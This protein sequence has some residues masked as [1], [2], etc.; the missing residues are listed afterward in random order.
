MTNYAITTKTDA[1]SSISPSLNVE[2]DVVNIAA[3]AADYVPELYLDLGNMQAGDTTIVTEY[4]SVDGINQ[5][6]YFQKTF[7]DVQTEPLLRLHGKLLELGMLYKVTVKQTGG[8]ARV[9][10]LASIIQIFNA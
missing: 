6:I 10:P 4:I 5:R 9:Y 7:K 3:Q 1:Q 2:T 8:T